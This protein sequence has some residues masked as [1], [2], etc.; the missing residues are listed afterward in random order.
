MVIY[1]Q[2]VKGGAGKSVVARFA[3]DHFISDGKN[4]L[5]ID[6]DTGNPDVARSYGLENGGK[7]CDVLGYDSSKEEGFGEVL[8]A[9]YEAG[10]AG[11]D[12]IVNCGARNQEEMTN[13]GPALAAMCA[14]NGLDLVTLWTIDTDTI[15]LEQLV[16][17]LD[18]MADSRVVIIR[19]LGLTDG[20]E[21]KF[22]F[23]DKT[24]IGKAVPSVY[25]PKLPDS[26]T[27]LLKSPHCKAVHELE[28]SLSMGARYLARGRLNAAKKAISDALEIAKKVK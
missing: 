24:K 20:D 21:A 13:F 19:N 14:E 28:D 23:V 15:C 26:V 27:E 7:G 10:Q 18:T 16:N 5:L 4:P 2:G 3:L 25:F 6:T 22:A 8:T 9:I 1:S 12:V 17:F 11:R